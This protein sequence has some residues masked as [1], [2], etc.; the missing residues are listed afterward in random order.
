MFKCA[1][2]TITELIVERLAYIDRLAIYI[3]IMLPVE[4]TD[5]AHNIGI[6]TL[7][8]TIDAHGFF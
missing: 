6:T 7:F 5:R 8:L 2:E 4:E 3:S 1:L